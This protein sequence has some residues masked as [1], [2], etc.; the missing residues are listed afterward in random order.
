MCETNRQSNFT[1][2]FQNTLDII[3]YAGKVARNFLEDSEITI[4]YLNVLSFEEPGFQVNFFI[5]YNIYIYIYTGCRIS[6]S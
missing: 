3:F 5:I 6:L 1:S 2:K 4:P